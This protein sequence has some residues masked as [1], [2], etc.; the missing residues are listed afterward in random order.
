MPAVKV[1]L[2]IVLVLVLGAVLQKPAITLAAPQTQAAG[3]M[4]LATVIDLS[5]KTQVDVGV[6]DFLVKEGGDE[7]EV[8]DVHIADYPIVVLI[9]DGPGSND[10][11]PIKSAIARFIARIGERPVAIGT[12]ARPTEFIASLEDSREDVLERLTNMNG[13]GTDASTL[14][15]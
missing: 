6:D 2:R 7:R 4:L 3:R 11:R 5:G 13:T 9:D 14:P 10:L 1:T 8:L 15:A 12:L